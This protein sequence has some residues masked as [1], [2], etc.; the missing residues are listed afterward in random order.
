[1]I[2]YVKAETAAGR[3]I[4]ST[5]DGRFYQDNRAPAATK[6]DNPR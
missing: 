3:K 6:G 5:L 2:D 4:K 1:V